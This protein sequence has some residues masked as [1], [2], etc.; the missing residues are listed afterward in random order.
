M[1]DDP[2]ALLRRAIT[3]AA[4]DAELTTALTTAQDQLA[5]LSAKASAAATDADRAKEAAASVASSTDAA[6][7]KQARDRL[8][9][10]MADASQANHDFEQALVKF[11]EARNTILRKTAKG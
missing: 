2:I 10:L 3:G 11:Q 9:Q 6:V 8:G 4:S 7:V 1:G 5:I